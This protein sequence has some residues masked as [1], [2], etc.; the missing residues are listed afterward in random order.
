MP[1]RAMYAARRAL[2]R[3]TKTERQW[4]VC[5]EETVL[6]PGGTVLVAGWF[7]WSGHGATAGDVLACQVVCRWLHA[8][9]RAFD[10][11]SVLPSLGGVD[12]RHVD[13]SAYSDVIFVCGPVGPQGTFSNL[14][15]RFPSSRHLGVDLTM[16]EPLETWNP[17]DV[18]I[19]RDSNVTSRPDLSFAAEPRQVPILGVVLVEPYAPEYE[20]RDMQSE[21][22][23]AVERLINSREAAV[24]EIDTR[25]EQNARGLRT[26]DEVASL[27]S[28]M[29]AVVT[30]RLHGLVLAVRNGVPALAV[31]PVSGGAKIRQQAEAIGWP[32]VVTA[33][34]LASTDLSAALDACLTPQARE[35]ARVCASRAIQN[36]EAIHAEFLAALDAPTSGT[37]VGA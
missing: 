7:S 25:L 4:R 26:A 6:A 31:D 22:R 1:H 35:L 33:E 29:D 5:P 12:W 24:V 36:V 19:E 8:A 21:A 18:L 37:S 20:G 9:G 14:L 10:V 32:Y 15:E 28:R 30:T 27:I 11:A 17:F 3:R 2:S 34:E 23:A 16:L 13:P